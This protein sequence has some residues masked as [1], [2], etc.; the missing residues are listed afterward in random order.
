[1]FSLKKNVIISDLSIPEDIHNIEDAMRKSAFCYNDKRFV[2]GYDTILS[3]KFGGTDLSGGEWQRLAVARGLYRDAN[4]VVLDEPTSAIDPIEESRVY[5]SFRKI[6]AGKTSVLITHRL[7]AAKLANK[8]YYLENGEILE[9]GT[10]LELL[11]R[12]GKYA[13]LYRLQSQWY[14]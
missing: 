14:Q 4:L 10:H 6:C 2:N 3:K 1:M 8:I 13:E 11:R 12:N 7:G 5:D 9:Q